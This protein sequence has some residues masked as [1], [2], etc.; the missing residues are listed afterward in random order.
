MNRLLLLLALMVMAACSTPQAP[1]GE[2]AAVNDTTPAEWPVPDPAD[3]S[4]LDGIMTA[5]YEVV[6]GPADEIRD[7]QRDKSLHAPGAQVVIMRSNDDGTPRIER[8][9]I[10]DY[11]ARQPGPAEAAFYEVEINRAVRQHGSTIHVWSTY[12]YRSTP[13]GPSEG[14]GVNSIE[15]VWDGFRYWI[16]SWSYDGRV[17]APPVPP[18]YLPTSPG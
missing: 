2:P 15:L 1:T 16:T 9:T 8:M 13:D 5:Y 4:T 3:V 11:H 17:D 10:S 6:S 18:E 7:W 14:Q 12:E